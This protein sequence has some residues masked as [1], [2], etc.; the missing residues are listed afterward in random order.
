MYDLLVMCMKYNVQFYH[1][2]YQL[3]Y[4]IFVFHFQFPMNFFLYDKC[5]FVQWKYHILK[6]HPCLFFHDRNL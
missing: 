2:Y 3:I 5:I 4:Y 6:I 1:N